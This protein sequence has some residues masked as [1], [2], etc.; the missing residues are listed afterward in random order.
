MQI[1]ANDIRVEPNND[2]QKE[3]VYRM[4]YELERLLEIEN[5][6]LSKLYGDLPL[7]CDIVTLSDKIFEDFNLQGISASRYCE[8]TTHSNYRFFTVTYNTHAYKNRCIE[9]VIH[10]IA[11]YFTS[12]VFGVNYERHG[13][14]F[15]TVMKQLF[16]HYELLEDSDFEYANLKATGNRVKFVDEALIELKALNET[17][18]EDMLKKYDFQDK[19]PF[20]NVKAYEYIENNKVHRVLFNQENNKSV[21]TV[22]KLFKFEKNNLKVEAMDKEK[23]LNYVLYS[24]VFSMCD[25]GEQVTNWTSY[26]GQPGFIMHRVVENEEGKLEVR[27]R[28]VRG[29]C[30]EEI[31][32]IK[33][34]MI[35]E[36]K[37]ESK[38]YKN[39]T[40]LKEYHNL[41][42]N[43]KKNVYGE[44]V[45]Y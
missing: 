29:Y 26:A 19:S 12:I 41:R 45:Y 3:L 40:T 42:K 2:T 23:L 32:E 11:H 10:E 27:R 15:T 5:V 43:L 18:T 13:A 1:K 7:D 35:K 24:P 34:E 37:S 14:F 28:V 17:E 8:R 16:K 25:R 39:A 38:K 31:K 21:Y 36:N 44:D 33:R 9:T 6:D 30:K 4:D 22:R 20:S